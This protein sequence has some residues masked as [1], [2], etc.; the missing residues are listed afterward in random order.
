MATEPQNGEDSPLNMDE[1]IPSQVTKS[2]RRPIILA[3]AVVLALAV[4]V[5][6]R[7]GLFGT[8]TLA[9][10]PAPKISAAETLGKAAEAYHRTDYAEAA[11]W[12]R[13]DRIG[14]LYENWPGGGAGL[15]R[16]DALVPTGR[17]PGKC[18]SAG[19]YRVVVFP[20]LGRG[21]GLRG[22]V[23]LVPQGRGAG[24]R[25]GAGSDW[26]VVRTG[27]GRSAGLCRG[28]A[29]V[30]GGC[31]AGKCQCTEQYRA[32]VRSRPGVAKDYSEAMRWFRK[33]A[34]QGNAFAQNKI[35]VLYYNGWSVKQDYGEAMRWFRKAADQ[36]DGA[37]QNNVG[38]LYA[39]GEGVPRDLG[40]AREWMQKAAAN[41]DELAKKWLAAN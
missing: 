24:R 10:S 38:W 14:W 5:S 2:A 31:G 29:L 3:G 7:S 40:Q 17:R 4:A 11:Y 30:P 12:Y 8:G 19:Q 41:G 37:A 20:R 27:L 1:R 16:G 32:A 26:A 28:D 15:W 6:L 9:P 33:A 35:G 21:T 39:N 18:R 36:G 23:T 13:R 25:V 22:G 34:D